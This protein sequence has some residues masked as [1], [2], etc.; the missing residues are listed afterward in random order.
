MRQEFDKKIK[1]KRN[2]LKGIGILEI[3]GGISGI[4]LI[5][6]LTLQ[7]METNTFVLL[8]LLFAIGFYAYSIYAGIRL[9]KYKEN[10]IFHSEILQWL[11][12]IAMS[13]GGMTYLLTSAG[14][15]FLGYNFTTSTLEFKLNF[16]ASE[17]QIDI[18][19]SEH[20][21][22]FFI[23]IM[24]IVILVLL[25]KSFNEIKNQKVIKENYKQNM[26]EYL[27]PESGIENKLN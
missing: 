11:Q 4:G 22:Y 23:N 1:I 13:Y 21:N 20:N 8:I 18:M 2:I 24:A 3:V 5:L 19:S 6:W 25:E 12:I 17:F 27:E 7:G 16:I 9:F 14:N 26:N 15:L 10:G